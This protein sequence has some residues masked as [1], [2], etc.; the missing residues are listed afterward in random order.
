[1]IHNIKYFF[2]F[3]ILNIRESQWLIKHYIIIKLK[4]NS[5]DYKKI[6]IYVIL[7]YTANTLSKGLLFL[8]LLQL[9]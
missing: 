6:I 7:N 1:M 3:I 4:Q 5:D 8:K 2:E 9:I